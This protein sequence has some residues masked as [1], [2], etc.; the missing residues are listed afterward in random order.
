MGTSSNHRS[1]DI[2]PW[3][4]ARAV[5]GSSQIDSSVQSTEL[6]RS[7]VGDQEALL[8]QRLGSEALTY[9]CELAESEKSP[10]KAADRFDDHLQANQ[11]A[12]LMDSVAKRA[13]IRAVAL[14]GGATSFGQELF[15]ETASYLASRE[16][17]SYVG[18]EGR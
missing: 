3:R 6:W 5:I 7:A 17:P 8:A 9:A 2:P 16:L 13:L 4:P 14:G 10:A 15:A 18:A 12:S 11:L 1:R